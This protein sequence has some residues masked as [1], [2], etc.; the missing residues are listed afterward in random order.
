MEL[1]A[2]WHGFSDLMAGI[3]TYY[4]CEGYTVN[5]D[6]CDVSPWQRMGIQTEVRLKLNFTLENGEKFLISPLVKIS[7]L[8]IFN[9]DS[10]PH[11]G[12]NYHMTD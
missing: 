9:M 11:E 10:S 4:W 12:L 2:F 5:L 8:S 7:I 3:A 1:S 6:E